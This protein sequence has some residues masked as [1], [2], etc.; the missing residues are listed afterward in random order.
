[1]E[2]KYKF[3]PFIDTFF[4]VVFLDLVKGVALGIIISVIF[5]LKGNLKKVYYFK[6]EEYEDV[7]QID[8]TQ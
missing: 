6:K 2:K 7:I 1:M 4:A 5:V 8:L 3:V